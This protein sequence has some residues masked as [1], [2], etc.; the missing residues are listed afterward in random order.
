MFF[1]LLGVNGC[2]Y[3]YITILRIQTFAF[4][5]KNMIIL[6]MDVRGKWW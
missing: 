3:S 5:Y 6:C 2:S 4:T 1:K